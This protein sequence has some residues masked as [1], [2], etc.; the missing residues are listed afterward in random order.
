MHRCVRTAILLVTLGLPLAGCEYFGNYDFDPTD[1][2]PGDIFNTKKKLPG[3]R[4]PVFPEGVPGTSRGVPPELVKG[5]QPTDTTQE[6]L[7][8]APQSASPRERRA[9][10]PP[11]PR[12]QPKSAPK[13][14]TAAT[15]S[16]QTPVDSRWPDEPLPQQ[17][18]PA[19]RQAVQPQQAPPQRQTAQP[20]QAQQPAGGVQWP[21]PP[22]ARSQQSSPQAGAGAAG[23]QVQWPDPP[24]PSA[25][26]R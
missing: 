4:K 19:P 15:Q 11:A 10:T 6:T 2:I 20:Q 9:L 23:S 17:Q 25:F 24:A 3:E 7:A 14:S 12:E 8:S 21:D 1:L 18:R 22:G 13:T 16:T 26:P 5:Y